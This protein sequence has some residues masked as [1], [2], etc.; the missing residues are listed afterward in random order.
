[1][2]KAWKSTSRDCF[3]QN[4][5]YKIFLSAKKAV[6]LRDNWFM[7]YLYFRVNNIFNK[8]NCRI[9]HY[10]GKTTLY[11]IINTPNL[12]A[13]VCGLRSHS[14]S[15]ATQHLH[16][17]CHCLCQYCC[18]VALS[19]ILRLC[20]HVWVNVYARVWVLHECVCVCVHSS[21]PQKHLLQTF[22]LLPPLLLLPFGNLWAVL[23]C[24]SL[25]LN[26]AG[27]RIHLHN[28]IM[29]QFHP[30]FPFHQRYFSYQSNYFRL[31]CDCF[32]EC[33][34]FT[35]P[36]RTSCW[37]QPTSVS[38]GIMLACSASNLLQSL[39]WLIGAII[40][41]GISVASI[42]VGNCLLFS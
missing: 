1:V 40:Q 25:H 13:T 24:S 2:L 3:K 33:Q 14:H 39:S 21:K 34:R 37:Q 9:K 4:P 20:L 36:H 17:L 23:K 8:N 16:A 29:I 22:R 30:T 7:Q 12:T 27:I 6:T 38:G 32:T 28:A 19:S 42:C 5:K 35:Q 41:R 15:H 18:F 26:D 31:S 11:I 10:P